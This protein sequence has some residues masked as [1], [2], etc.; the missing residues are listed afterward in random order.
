MEYIHW[1]CHV[2]SEKSPIEI[3]YLSIQQKNIEI[4][5]R[6]KYNNEYTQKKIL[7]YITV[8]EDF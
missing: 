8:I 2:S 5:D 6:F 4:M 1:L 7:N 3:N